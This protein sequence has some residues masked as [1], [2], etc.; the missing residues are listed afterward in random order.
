MDPA[1]QGANS[2]CRLLTCPTRPSPN[3]RRVGVH[4][5]TFEMLICGRSSSSHF[6]VLPIRDAVFACS[7]LERDD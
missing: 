7:G 2:I 6:C 5:F 3:L 4:D 1:L